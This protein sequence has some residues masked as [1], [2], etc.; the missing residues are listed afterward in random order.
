MFGI[1]DY[2]AFVLAVIVFLAIPGPGNL[3]LLTSTAKGGLR[4]G[5]A[6]GVGRRAHAG[7]GL[8]LTARI[9]QVGPG[10]FERGK[11]GLAGDDARAGF[12]CDAPQVPRHGRGDNVTL[13]HLRD[14]FFVDRHAQ[15]RAPD[16]R[17]LD[18]N[19]ARSQAE[20]DEHQQHPARDPR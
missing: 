2:P 3:A 9:E 16:R 14:A 7:F 18:G 15:R 20:P 13:P 8:G 19:R 5:L 17:H 11:H 10:G 6:Q 1:A 12:Q 4:G